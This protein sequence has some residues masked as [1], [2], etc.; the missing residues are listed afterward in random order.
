MATH[1]Y[2]SSLEQAWQQ[3]K[4]RKEMIRKGWSLCMLGS[5]YDPEFQTKALQ[6]VN[7]RMLIGNDDL[8]SFEEVEQ[9]VPMREMGDP[10]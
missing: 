7:E 2:F 5:I 1:I 4:E 8:N 9:V 3:L 6:M 10:P